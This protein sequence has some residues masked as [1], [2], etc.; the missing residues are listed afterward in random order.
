MVPVFVKKIA[1]V[2]PLSVSNSYFVPTPGRLSERRDIEDIREM[3]LKYIMLCDVMHRRI[4]SSGKK[5][6][7]K[8]EIFFG[9]LGF[10]K[11]SERSGG[12]KCNLILHLTLLRGFHPPHIP[13]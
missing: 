3:I 11:V 10:S 13:C 5:E 9:L 12:V 6:K 7:E 1:T 8:G 4:S 2:S